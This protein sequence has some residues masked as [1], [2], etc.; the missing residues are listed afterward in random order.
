M[1]CYDVYLIEMAD[2][3]GKLL[4]VCANRSRASDFVQ[5]AGHFHDLAERGTSGKKAGLS[6][7]KRDGWQVL[8]QI[9]NWIFLVCHTPSVQS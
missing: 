9:V 8:K 4:F 6:H 7:Q 5:K 3:F 1:F 2:D